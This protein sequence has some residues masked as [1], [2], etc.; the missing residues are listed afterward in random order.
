MSIVAPIAFVFAMLLRVDVRD[1]Y[2]FNSE[3]KLGCYPGLAATTMQ[4]RS[5]TLS[6]DENI[7][8]MLIA[9]VNV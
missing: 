7:E 8:S 2:V 1:R 6:T 3:R 9:A 4:E 5:A